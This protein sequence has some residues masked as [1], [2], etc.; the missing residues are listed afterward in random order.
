M[1]TREEMDALLAVTCPWCGAAVGEH[2]FV[3][4]GKTIARPSTLD[5]ESHEARWQRALGMNARVL[6]T[7]ADLRAGRE[8]RP[9]ARLGEAATAVLDRPW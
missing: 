9:A 1:A 3:R 2:C 4:F 5:G 7:Q 6:S 8:S